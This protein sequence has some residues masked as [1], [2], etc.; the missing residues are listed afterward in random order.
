MTIKGAVNPNDPDT[1]H[2]KEAFLTCKIDSKAKQ[3][4]IR[5]TPRSSL[6]S[7]LKFNQALWS[8]ACE[9]YN[10]NNR[11]LYKRPSPGFL[12]LKKHISNKAAAQHKQQAKYDYHRC[13]DHHHDLL[14]LWFEIVMCSFKCGIN[15]STSSKIY[16]WIQRS[17]TKWNWWRLRSDCPGNSQQKGPCKAKMDDPRSHNYISS[18]CPSPHTYMHTVSTYSSLWN[19]STFV[20]EIRHPRAF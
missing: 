15:Q 7:D 13:H 16:F 19:S 9:I 6:R 8:D 20:L 5:A 3:S 17:L 10:Q 2:R 18:P 1:W 11:P 14:L 12:I 4:W